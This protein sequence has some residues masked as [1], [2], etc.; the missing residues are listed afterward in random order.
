MREYLLKSIMYNGDT[1]LSSKIIRLDA[2]FIVCFGVLHF[3][4]PFVLPTNFVNTSIFA[5]AAAPGAILL[6]ILS[7]VYY[8]TKNR[9][10]GFFLSFLYAGGVFFH[11]LFLAGVFP[12][13]LIVPS[14]WVLVVGLVLDV[15]VILTIVDFYLRTH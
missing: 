15:L 11:A 1:V 7:L 2:L 3:G 8:F 13:I 12:S 10:S 4:I 6:A 5:Y 9:Y 14:T